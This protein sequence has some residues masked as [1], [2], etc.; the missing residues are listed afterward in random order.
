MGRF[1][2]FWVFFFFGFHS[3]VNS[4]FSK[5]AWST[6]CEKTVLDLKSERGGGGGGGWVVGGEKE[7][8][9]CEFEFNLGYRYWIFYL[10]AGSHSQ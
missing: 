1:K 10:L 3:F 5:L 6:S 2:L 7:S 9:Y 4:I 8:R